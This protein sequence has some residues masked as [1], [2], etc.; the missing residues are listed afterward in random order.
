MNKF[1]YI[2]LF[3]FLITAYLPGQSYAQQKVFTTDIDNFWTAYDSIRTTKDSLKQIHFVQTLYIDKGTPGLK[4][5]M[6]ARDYSAKLYVELT[7]K[8]PKF[9]N[10]IRPN[11]LTVKSKANEIENSIQKLRSIYPELK[12]AKIYFT[13]GGLRSGGTTTD[14]MVLI[15]TEIATGNASTNVSE[16]TDK[17]LA[18]V[19]KESSIDNIVTLNVHEYIHTQQ[20]GES[21]NLLAQAIKEGSCDFISELVTGKPLQRN[22]IKY[23]K[24]HENELKEK[25]KQDMFSTAY[26]RWLYNGA[27]ADSVA[28]LGYF[29]GYEV[30]KSYYKNSNDKKQAVKNIIELNYS[31]T[32]AVETFLKKS[33]YYIEAINKEHLLRSFQEKQPILVKLEPFDNGDTMV[34]TSIKQA[35]LIFSKP[36]GKGYSISLGERG[37]DFFPIKG[38]VGFSDDKKRFTLQINLQSNHEYEFMIT[39]KSFASTDGYPLFKQYSIKFKTK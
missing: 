26:S 14:D 32:T 10:S 4:A 12:N 24:R 22:Y 6:D 38:V 30:C 37:K 35:I 39:N 3:C 27:T 21:A 25:F 17:W 34:D 31:D 33:K 9:W 11:T 5:F 7:N 36:M 23:G 1:I 15:G 28:D 8:Y 29:I 2:V 20:H 16:F 19:F 18:S 13:V